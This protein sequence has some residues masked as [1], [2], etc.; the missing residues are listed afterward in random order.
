MESRK[1]KH[2][3]GVVVEFIYNDKGNIV[4]SNIE[5]PEGMESDAEIQDKLPI[6]KR[7]FWNPETCTMVGYQRAL[8]LKLIKSEQQDD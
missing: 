1:F 6:T 4:E 8:Q 3:D 2:S 5:Y 7:T